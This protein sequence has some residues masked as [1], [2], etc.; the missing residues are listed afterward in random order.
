M[1]KVLRTPYPEES[2]QAGSASELFLHIFIRPERQ[3]GCASRLEVSR[4]S[5]MGTKRKAKDP[6]PATKGGEQ[7]KVR[8]GDNNK[9]K[10][11]LVF[12]PRPDWHSAGLPQL[13]QN[14]V[15]R[16]PPQTTLDA[17]YKHAMALLEAENSAYNASHTSGSSSH[18]FFSTIMSS[19]TLEDRVSALT[20]LV[21]ESPLH[22]VKAFDSLIG[23]A[24]K[25]N[26]NQALMA[27]AALKDLLG[28][29]VVLPVRKLKKFARQPLL[30]AALQGKHVKW[31]PGEPLP[32][33]LQPIHLLLWAYED[34][35]K[36]KYFELMQVLE[37]WCGDEVAH[38]RSR[39]VT[40]V[41]ELLKDKPEQEENLLRLLVNKLGDTDRKIASRASYLIL[42]LQNTHPAMKMEITKGIETNCLLRPNQSAHAKY[43][44]VI[45]LNQTILAQ[46]EHQ[47]AN[48]LLDIYFSIFIE[49]LRPADAAPIKKAPTERLQGGGGK[50]GK[51]AA[52]KRK[53]EERGEDADLQL[54]EKLIAQVLTGVNR[55]FPFADTSD[56]T[57]E[58]QIDTLFR[59]AHSAN[60]NTAVQALVLL[61]Q[62]SSSKHYGAD[63]FYRA[64][65]ETLLDPRLC[66]SSKQIMF[67]NLLFK[68]LKTD[69]N[70]KRVQAFVKRLLQAL[71]MHQPAFVCGV[72][73]L[74]SELEGTFPSVRCMMVDPEAGDDDGEEHF[75]DVP[76]SDDEPPTTSDQGRTTGGAPRYDPRKRDPEHAHAEHSALWDLL[77]YLRHFHPSV[78]LF[79]EALLEGKEMPPKPDPTHYT[80]MHFL[81]RFVYRSARS[82][83]SASLHG[84]SVMQPLAGNMEV[85][86]LLY[87]PGREGE[88]RT[89]VNTES[90]WKKKVED[91]AADEV[92]FH[93]YFNA[94]GK[95][96]RKSSE[97]KKVS[98]AGD[99]GD[100]DEGE[101][102]E[103][104]K[105]IT[106]SKPEVEGL[107]DEDDVSMGD[108]DSAY[109]ESEDG[110]QAGID[111]G[112]GGDLSD[113][114]SGQGSGGEGIPEL[115]SDDDALLDDED[116]LPQG[117]MKLANE[118]A[119]E[120]DESRNSKKRKGKKKIKSL[121]TFASAED[122]AKLL[123]QDEDEEFT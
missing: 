30:L 72:L 76:E 71:N 6:P 25:K 103:I 64:L 114:D 42:Q 98:V 94:A 56:P 109:S 122:Y 108:L 107:D 87:R 17:L 59:V 86:N 92:F 23:L 121:P 15:T 99:D 28:Q 81:D 47:L 44:A 101:E 51:L 12:Q 58:K 2:S 39:A 7:K 105:A 11:T 32:G 74:I 66:S 83:P 37:T 49:L 33:G 68:S 52:K 82:K 77:P 96:K 90:F 111:L 91:V 5:S 29:G 48:K 53:Q 16:L 31:T 50:A 57:F 70:A 118:A 35:L 79:A 112:G 104:W 75:Q 63:R 84:S 93:A 110:S 67:L 14:D 62:I 19:G 69:L 10:S 22:A 61:Q 97:K 34:W 102:E 21:Q 9:A 54:R 1:W 24:G 46:K 88:A 89:H 20:L 106:A 73:Y 85:A 3:Y 80:L 119:E 95:Q 26:R 41:F 116:D 4:L 78:S 115:E 43:Y 65:Y 55:A 120:G 40:Y 123:D 8:L 100:S 117:F 27:L 45:T 36:T 113:D 13:E 18:K 60:F 38:A